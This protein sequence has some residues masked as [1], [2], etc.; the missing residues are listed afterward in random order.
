ME[1]DRSGCEVLS[2]DECLRLLSTETMGRLGLH[3]GALP[4]ILPVAYALVDGNVVVRTHD[5]AQIYG[6][7][8]DA[9]VAFEVDRPPGG[10]DGGWSVHVTGLAQE[11]TDPCELAR[12]RALPLRRWA[13][14]DADRFVRISLQL[15]SGRRLSPLPA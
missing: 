15:M 8:R 4:V 11:V 14:D 6:A 7:A 2:R 1:V 13:Q 9:V 10:D 3:A 5:G 12:L